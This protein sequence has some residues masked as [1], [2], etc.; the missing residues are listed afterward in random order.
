MSWNL[1]YTLGNSDL[2]LTDRDR[3]PIS[4]GKDGF[5]AKTEEIYRRLREE[6]F[7]VKGDLIILSDMIVQFIM[8]M[9][10]LRYL[11][12]KE[13]SLPYRVYL[14]A[15]DQETYKSQDTIYL[16]KILKECFLPKA[17]REDF[18]DKV[19][20]EVIRSHNPSSYDEMSEFFMS[21][22]GREKDRISYATNNYTQVSAGTPAMNMSLVLSLRSLPVNLN[23]FSLVKVG[24]GMP[25]EIKESLFLEK[26]IV[27]EAKAIIEGLIRS[28]SYSDALSVLK[29]FPISGSDRL[30]TLLEV[31]KLRRLFN[32]KGALDKIKRLDEGFKSK[33][34]F[35]KYFSDILMNDSS[36]LRASFEEFEI[37][38]KKEEYH[39]ACAAMF[40]F[41]DLLLDFSIAKL[42][43]TGLI[44]NVDE[45]MSYPDKIKALK[46]SKLK[47][48][49]QLKRIA[50]VEGCY[51]L[52]IEGELENKIAGLREIRNKGPFAHG[53][54]QFP[55]NCVDTLKTVYVGIKGLFG[56]RE[57]FYDKANEVLIEELQKL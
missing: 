35:L 47:M 29:S 2:Y 40:N 12:K 27:S 46:E 4:I 18:S 45:R 5:R 22:L 43:E 16:A 48:S 44:E 7:E 24:N 13:S 19:Q 37:Y 39:S 34:I 57:N 25:P 31:L 33:K 11:I 30:E 6:S 17:I 41:T 32:F 36:R 14:F 55:E 15:T 9:P 1:F 28:Y 3:K 52:L 51:A 49:L 53:V 23:I 8:F 20:I 10:F 38:L 42:R 26:L 54:E 56:Y 21:F 50:E